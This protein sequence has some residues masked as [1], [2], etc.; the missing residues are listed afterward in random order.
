VNSIGAHDFSR[1]MGRKRQVDITGYRFGRLL[2]MGPSRARGVGTWHCRCDCGA[3]RD[4][5]KAVLN[6]GKTRSCGCL[7]REIAQ[8]GKEDIA[9]PGCQVMFVAQKCRGAIYCSRVC[10]GKA[11]RSK[12][13]KTCEHCRGAFSVHAFRKY[14]A[15]FCS[16]RCAALD[17]GKALKVSLRG[18]HISPKTEFKPGHTPAQTLSGDEAAFN[19]LLYAY[20]RAARERR[21]VF[22][23]SREQFRRLTKM[24]CTYCGGAPASIRRTSRSSY[25]FNGIDR[26]NNSDGYVPEN[27]V[28]CCIHCNRAKLQRTI[29]QFMSWIRR[30]IAACHGPRLGTNCSVPVVAKPSARTALPSGESSFRAL[31]ANY[32]TAAIRRDIPF[33]LSMD[34]FRQLTTRQCFYCG[35]RPSNVKRH[36]RGSYGAYI[37]SGVDRADNSLGYQPENCRPCCR[38]CNIAKSDLSED[39]FLSWALRVNDIAARSPE[40]LSMWRRLDLMAGRV[41]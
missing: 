28:P 40:R 26:E 6:A 2:V 10:S 21:I 14:A 3:T 5:T 39:E 25:T 19:N 8:V 35:A 20:Q 22:A 17:A 30:I 1:D 29:P 4:V 31:Y 32:R 15:R 18:R 41:S 11:R 36:T 9:C 7:S 12:V 33:D 34:D 37:Y 23:L 13:D 24:D 16:G 27:S 38:D